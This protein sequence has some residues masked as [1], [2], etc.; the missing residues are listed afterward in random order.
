MI[1]RR[2]KVACLCKE[3]HG[4]QKL[5]GATSPSPTM[6]TNSIISNDWL[7]KKKKNYRLYKWN[8]IWLEVSSIE[9][10]MTKN[11]TGFEAL[12]IY[13]TSNSGQFS[14]IDRWL[15]TNEPENSNYNT[16]AKIGSNV[17][18]NLNKIS[19]IDSRN[20][21]LNDKKKKQKLN[22]IRPRRERLLK[23]NSKK[24]LIRPMTLYYEK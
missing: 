16:E 4:R 9:L 18:E 11:N 19:M 14:I 24:N 10:T 21:L 6:L 20:Q 23:I 13:V 12:N 2:S 1:D 5:K 15:V 7:L 22:L 17:L 8:N 3:S